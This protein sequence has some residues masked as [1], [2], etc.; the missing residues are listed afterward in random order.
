MEK[1]MRKF[2]LTCALTCALPAAL[3]W[4]QAAKPVKVALPAKPAGAAA[5]TKQAEAITAAEMRDYLYFIASDALE[6]RNTPSRGLDVAAEFIRYHLARW[7][8]KPGGDNGAYFQ[9]IWL[10]R[11]RI[12][13]SKI[14]LSGKEFKVNEDFFAFRYKPGVFNGP[15]VFAG[16][17]WM[18]KAKNINAYQGLEVKDKIVVIAANFRSNGRPAGITSED[19]KGAKGVDWADPPTYA[20]ANGAK[21]LLLVLS[22]NDYAN[23]SQ[24]RQFLG[25]SGRYRMD[26]AGASEGDDIPVLI[27]S[28]GMA[29]ALFAGEKANPAD[30]IALANDNAAQTPFEFNDKN[31][32]ITLTGEVERTKTQNV[33]GIVEGSDPVLKNEYVAIGS[34]YDH[35][36]IGGCGGV[37]EKDNICN[38]A[39]DDGSGTVAVLNLARAFAISKPRPKRS[40]IFVWH[41]GEEKGLWGSEYFANNSTVPLDKIV[42]QLNIDMIGRSK[43][44]GDTDRRNATLTGPKEI[45]VIGSKLMS[46]EL[47]ALSERVNA[48]YLN[49]A[50]NYKY[51]DPNDTERLFYRSDHYNY[52]KKGIPIIFYFDGVHEDYHQ[53]GDH[54]DKID[55]EKM[56][57]VTRTI[58]MTGWEIANLPKRPTVDKKL[59]R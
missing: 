16:N 29:E 57:M 31:A 52:A 25:G 8:V 37:S 30:V 22:G 47:G 50:F 46:T 59:D 38:G 44:E 53:A 19:L 58:F 18:V 48:S 15:L 24:Y 11:R 10:T 41:T 39:D 13:D 35:V 20:K 17:G 32:G 21:A 2:L 56:E 45:Y 55:Y 3:V 4:A 27:V 54:P 6:G 14:S 23:W 43:K 7:G 51:D 9:D 5:A 49:L 26:A 1:T 33:I 28:K 34:H 40:I 12:N 36:G 42:V